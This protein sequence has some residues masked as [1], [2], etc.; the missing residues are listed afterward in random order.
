LI[1][2]RT[3]DATL[4]NL[5]S[6]DEFGASTDVGSSSSSDE[7]CV[8]DVTPEEVSSEFYCEEVRRSNPVCLMSP[9]RR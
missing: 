7:P 2:F 5:L 6:G 4:E 3:Q 8:P 1:V 9:P